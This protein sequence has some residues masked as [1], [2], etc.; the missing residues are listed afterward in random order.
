VTDTEQARSGPSMSQSIQASQI[1]VIDPHSEWMSQW[2]RM[3]ANLG[4]TH[5]RSTINAHPCPCDLE[6]LRRFAAEHGRMNELHNTVLEDSLVS[7]AMAVDFAL[8][9]ESTPAAESR[10]KLKTG[11]YKTKTQRAKQHGF[12]SIQLSEA[13]R[14]DMVLPGSQLFIDFCDSLVA[15]YHLNDLLVQGF[16]A[17]IQPVFPECPP[18]VPCA[19]SDIQ[20]KHNVEPGAERVPER[21]I[22]TLTDGRCFS[23]ATV[24]AALGGTNL[25]NKPAWCVS[26]SDAFPTHA[27]RHAWQLA[28]Q[29]TH[30][31][32]EPALPQQSEPRH[33]Q[34][35]QRPEQDQEQAHKQEQP[36]EGS[37]GVST[38]THTTCLNQPGCPAHVDFSHC[39][40]PDEAAPVVSASL[41]V[42][43]LSNH[44]VQEHIVVVGGGLTSAQLCVK[45]L[46]D[47][48]ARRVTLVMRKHFRSVKQFDVVRFFFDVFFLK[49][50][51]SSSLSLSLS[52]CSFFPLFLPL[53]LITTFN[54]CST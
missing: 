43:L 40:E 2:K 28:L 20:C 30:P 10:G 52:L 3:F 51:F 36:H 42:K 32:V 9:E 27:L 11:K 29:D 8:F 50:C 39:S 41:A 47:N 37:L 16:V 26:A 31:S 21:F 12:G 14:N 48:R 6:S 45:A 24:V 35:Q 46:K 23:A 38:S 54:F 33:Q 17:D 25:P 18:E 7:S 22:V 49:L 53:S 15:K 44:D 13:D 4:I 1:A 5:L 19:A 34:H